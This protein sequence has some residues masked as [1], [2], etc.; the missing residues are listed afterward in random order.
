MWPCCKLLDQMQIVN[1]FSWFGSWNMLLY[2]FSKYMHV[3]FRMRE[4]NSNKAKKVP[5][6]LFCKN[7]VIG[8]LHLTGETKIGEGTNFCIS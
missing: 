8:W 6:V 4:K 3:W 5:A 1:V 7:Y 2:P